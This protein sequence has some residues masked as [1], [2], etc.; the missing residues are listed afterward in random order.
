[1]KTEYLDLS[2]VDSEFLELLMKECRERIID[3][4]QLKNYFFDIGNIQVKF[5]TNAKD[6]RK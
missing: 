4:Y 6:N 2:T 1:M 5:K 3:K